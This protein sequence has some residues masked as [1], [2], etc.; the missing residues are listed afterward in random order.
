MLN[1]VLSIVSRCAFGLAAVLCAG[2]NVACGL[3]LCSLD[4]TNNCGSSLGSGRLL[5]MMSCFALRFAGAM[6]TTFQPL[7]CGR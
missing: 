6:F 7:G 5:M 1:R 2:T 3:P 4:N